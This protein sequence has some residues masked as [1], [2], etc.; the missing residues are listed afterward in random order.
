MADHLKQLEAEPIPERGLGAES[1]SKPGL[2]TGVASKS[3]G[4]QSLLVDLGVE[5]VPKRCQTSEQP[6]AVSSIEDEDGPAEPITIACLSK[7]IQFV[8]HK[9]L[10][11]QMELSEIEEL[12][13]RLIREEAGRAF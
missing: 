1:V 9:I 8:N 10:S 13:K 5:P 6:R 3:A 2:D 12:L 11:S 7:T 4:K